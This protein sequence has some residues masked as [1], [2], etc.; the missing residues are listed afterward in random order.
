MFHIDIRQL[1]E[2][3]IEA[4]SNLKEDSPSELPFNLNSYSGSLVP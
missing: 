4:V 2:T 3:L 1:E